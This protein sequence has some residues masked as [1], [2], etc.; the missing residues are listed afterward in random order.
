MT[1]DATARTADVGQQDDPNGSFEDDDIEHDQ[2]MTTDYQSLHR[3]PSIKASVLYDFNGENIPDE[4]N[5]CHVT[6]IGHGIDGCQY[7]NAVTIST[8]EC[9]T[10]LEDDQGDGWARIEKINGSTGFVP[11]S[12]LRIDSQLLPSTPFESNRF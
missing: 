12:Y 5:L 10:V 9:V 4:K 1:L 7:A 6:F 3:D 8:G 11:S 2:S